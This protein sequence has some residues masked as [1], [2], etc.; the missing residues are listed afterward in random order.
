MKVVIAAA[1][2][3]TRMLHLSQD[4]PKHLIQI[5]GRPWM[6]H[7]FDHV[8]S[9]GL[10]DI[11]LV[12]GYQAH[13]W[14]E[15]LKHDTHDIE[16]TLV[17]QFTVCGT[18]HHGTA[19]SLEAAKDVVGEEQFIFF[20]GDNIYAPDDLKKFCVQDEYLYI[21]GMRHPEPHRFGVLFEE[22][23]VLKKIVEKPQE[24]VGDMINVGLYKFTP[25]IFEAVKQI[26]M[27]PRGEY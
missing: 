4:K 15:F 9:A 12:V 26:D 14:D 22:N 5:N 6:A 7:V 17:N 21:G 25:E 27:S 10:N 13:A 8:V 16:V 18:E 24:F 2:K 23:G 1:G 3:G 20:Y 19:V 11:V